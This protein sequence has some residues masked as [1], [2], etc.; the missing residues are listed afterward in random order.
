MGF[1]T[2][3]FKMIVNP[4]HLGDE[5]ID[6]IEKSYVNYKAALKPG[7]DLHWILAHVWLRRR[8]LCGDKV[9]NALGEDTAMKETYMFACLLPPTCVR[10]LGIFMIGKEAPKVLRKHPEFVEELSRIM[11]PVMRAINNGTS[12][13]L[14]KKY[15]PGL[16]ATFYRNENELY[17]DKL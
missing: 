9:D 5:I 16:A 13:L 3:F 12:D 4:K 14:Y 2:N 11:A 15:S 10:A 6:C 1:I 17:K 7:E 8:M